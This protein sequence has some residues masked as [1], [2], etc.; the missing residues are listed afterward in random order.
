[1]PHDVNDTKL[2]SAPR[3]VRP[4]RRKSLSAPF[5]KNA[6][7]AHTPQHG[8]ICWRS[9]GR[10]IRS[11]VEKLNKRQGR[12]RDSSSFNQRPTPEYGVVTVPFP[13]PREEYDHVME[14]LAPLEIGDS[15][16]RDCR[17]EEISGDFPVLKQLEQTNTILMSLINE[18]YSNFEAVKHFFKPENKEKLDEMLLVAHSMVTA[19]NMG[20]V[21]IDKA[22]WEINVIEI[23]NVVRYGD[24]GSQ[25][26]DREEF[27][28]FQTNTQFWRNP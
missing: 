8:F 16:A 4:T 20:K 22:P 28:V 27:R 21:V 25:Q 10:C 3:S 14:L 24:K 23:L 15:V 2:N 17:I 13:I 7:G 1:M 5:L 26:S 9:D 6:G 19:V 11:E 18:D 12:Q